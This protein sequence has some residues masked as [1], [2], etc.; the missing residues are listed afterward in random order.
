MWLFRFFAL[1]TLKNIKIVFSKG[2][3]WGIIIKNV[4]IYACV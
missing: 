4:F 1:F 3:K 2:S